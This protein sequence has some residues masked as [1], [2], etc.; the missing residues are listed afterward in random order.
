[1]PN[2]K[3]HIGSGIG[4]YPFLVLIHELARLNIKNERILQWL[5]VDPVIIAVGY[6]VFVFSADAPDI[7][8]PDSIVQRIARLLVGIVVTIMVFFRLYEYWNRHKSF[9]QKVPLI[10]LSFF[11]AV[12]V[13]VFATLIFTHFM[14]RHRGVIHTVWAGTLYAL[15]IA[16]GHWLFQQGALQ[17][18]L[19]INHTIFL[20]VSSFLGYLLHISLDRLVTRIRKKS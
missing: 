9:D 14:P 12:L 20:G 17:R 5:I 11:I 8:H 6:A 16:G 4:L 3:T 19:L 18:Q 10:S 2:F 1:M 7:D 15:T 13:G